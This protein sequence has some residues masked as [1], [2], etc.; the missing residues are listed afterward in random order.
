VIVVD[1]KAH[2]NNSESGVQSVREAVTKAT[3]ELIR[4]RARRRWRR[5][6]RLFSLALSGGRLMVTLADK[7]LPPGVFDTSKIPNASTKIYATGTAAAGR[8]LSASSNLAVGILGLKNSGAQVFGFPAVPLGEL[9][10][11]GNTGC[12][13]LEDMAEV[14]TFLRKRF[15]DYVA[16]AYNDLVTQPFDVLVTSIGNCRDGKS[17]F[18]EELREVAPRYMQAVMSNKDIV[19]ELLYQPIDQ[20][21]AVVHLDAEEEIL[22]QPYI[23]LPLSRL[24][25]LIQSHNTLVVLCA[26]DESQI[27]PILAARNGGYFNAIVCTVEVAKELLERT[28]E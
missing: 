8:S 11:A 16:N 25:E 12:P 13:H 5:N 19:G 3:A 27:D 10:G 24:T 17:V 18:V 7:G 28:S 22:S 15:G 26:V 1:C 14:L 4:E 20:T 21:G 2:G 23:S 9:A 6:N